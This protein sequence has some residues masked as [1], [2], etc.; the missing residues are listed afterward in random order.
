MPLLLDR[1]LSEHRRALA[2]DMTESGFGR[3]RARR[4]AREIVQGVVDAQG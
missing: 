1:V 4:Y 3:R 2:H